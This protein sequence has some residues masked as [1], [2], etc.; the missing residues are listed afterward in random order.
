MKVMSIEELHQKLVN[1]EIDVKEYY[2]ELF[3]EVDFQQKRLNAFVTVTKDEALKNIENLDLTKEQLKEFFEDLNYLRNYHDKNEFYITRGGS[4][5]HDTF[6]GKDNFRCNA[7]NN[8]VMITPDSKVYGCNAI[9][10]PGYEIGEFI[11]NKVYLY[12]KFYHDESVCL[13]ELLGYLNED[14]MDNLT[15][16]KYPVLVKKYSNKK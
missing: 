1:H 8:H 5:G 11:N 15:Y 9:C 10:R 13:A 14:N 2:Q 4:L 12:K 16:D 3:E 6:K 7:G